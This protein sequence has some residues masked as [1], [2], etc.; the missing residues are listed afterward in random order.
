MQ[1]V[2]VREKEELR[3]KL[4][5]A[6]ATGTD[7]AELSMCAGRNSPRDLYIEFAVSFITH[8]IKG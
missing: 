5:K 2:Y 6:T 8:E 1:Q 3:L 7:L 4:N